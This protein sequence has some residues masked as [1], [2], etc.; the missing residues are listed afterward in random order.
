[1]LKQ[2][3]THPKLYDLCS[4]LG[5]TRPL[6]IGYLELLWCFTADHSADG[7]VG[8]WP[9][10]S[11]ARACEW[12]GDAEAFVLA[13]VA[14]GWLD[15][16]ESHRLVVHDWTDHCPRWVKAKV[17]RTTVATVVGTTVAT[18]THTHIHTQKP[19][20]KPIKKERVRFVPPTLEQVLEYCRG[21]RSPSNAQPFLDHYTSNGWKVGRNPMKDWQASFRNWCSRQKEFGGGNGQPTKRNPTAEWEAEKRANGTWRD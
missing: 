5:C 20:P 12:T 17:A 16:C 10:G 18:H 2:G 3:L 11:I 15:P 7:T 13:L 6:A 14:T 8:R 4:H 1:M 9:D 19:K 21:D